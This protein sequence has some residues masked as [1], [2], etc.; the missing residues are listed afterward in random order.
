MDTWLLSVTTFLPAVAGA[1]LFLLRPDRD[2]AS[3][4]LALAATLA[5][6]ALA[7]VACFAFNPSHGGEFQFP[8]SAKWISSMGIEIRYAMGV[9]GISLAM[10]ALTA[11]LTP[12]CV[13]CSWNS[14]NDRARGFIAAVSIAGLSAQTR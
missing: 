11:L 3:K 14:V 13:L 9:D 8:V 1:G 4:V 10:I 12:L 7:A 5:T 6:L 2:R